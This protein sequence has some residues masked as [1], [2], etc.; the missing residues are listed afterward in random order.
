MS[1]KHVKKAVFVS[2]MNPQTWKERY[3]TEAKECKDPNSRKEYVQLRPED[4]KKYGKSLKWEHALLKEFSGGAI[5]Q[6]YK[7]PC[8][9]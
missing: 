2:N 4:D 9:D 5:L 3:G 7:L 8:C 6:C 1:H